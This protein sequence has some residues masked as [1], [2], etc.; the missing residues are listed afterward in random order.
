LDNHQQLNNSNDDTLAD[1]GGGKYTDTIL[2]NQLMGNHDTVERTLLE[3]EQSG[4]RAAGT[5]SISGFVAH[6]FGHHLINDLR[7]KFPDIFAQTV[8]PILQS[9]VSEGQDWIELNLSGLAS[10]KPGSVIK[11]DEVLAEAFAESKMSKEPRKAAR[12]IGQA[13]DAAYSKGTLSN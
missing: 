12:E 3:M 13:L 4:R 6:E 10:G 9:Y 2:L 7:T 11:P 8:T 5:G 1:C